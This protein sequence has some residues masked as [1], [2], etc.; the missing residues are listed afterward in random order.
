MLNKEYLND[1]MQRLRFPEEARRQLL[2]LYDL[3]NADSTGAAE[4]ESIINDYLADDI[5]EP[6]EALSRAD[7]LAQRLGQS[8]Y[9]VQMLF[10]LGCTRLLLPRYREQGFE[11][12]VF[13]D[14]MADLRYK[15]LECMEC[16]GVAGTFV[17]GWF[18]GFFAMAR[19]AVGRFEYDLTALSA[20]YTAPDGTVYKKGSP[21][22]NCHIPSSGIPLTD[23]VRF[24]SYRRAYEFFGRHFAQLY[25]GK[26]LIITCGSWLLYTAHRDF[27]PKQLNILRFMDD[28]DI[29]SC[30]EKPGFGNDWRV[31]GRYAKLPYA[32]LP[33]DTS[34]RRAYKKHLMEKGVSGDG[35][36]VLI[37]D[38]EK[39]IN[40]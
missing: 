2:E 22:L 28:F 21:S 27:L 10:W 6:S 36:G 11:D 12:E 30:T 24:D 13:Y 19:F 25:A 15:L 34:L 5:C 16:K 18:H 35:Y 33:E 37:F 29:V 3:L 7:D 8:E 20:D 39:I 14:S 1:I 26:P 23:E 31:F 9:A 40:K 38:G 32:E 4:L 17:G